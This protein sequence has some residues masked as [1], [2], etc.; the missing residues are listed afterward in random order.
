M[1][2]RTSSGRRPVLFILVL[3][4]F[5]AL[6]VIAAVHSRRND[7]KKDVAGAPAAGPAAAAARET[8]PAPSAGP[9]AQPAAGPSAPGMTTAPV[10]PTPAATISIAPDLACGEAGCDDG[11]PCTVD[12]CDHA[13]GECVHPP[14]ICDDFNP[15]TTE[16]CDPETGCRSDPIPDGA[17]CGPAVT[18]QAPAVC[19]AGQCVSGRLNCDDGDPCTSDGCDDQTGECVH[20]TAGV[21]NDFNGCTLDSCD[22]QTGQC[23]H[24]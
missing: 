24:T 18:C 10:A 4:A 13:T 21:C 5:L 1:H 12:R 6:P 17:S 20:S 9:G 16:T 11:D 22:A 14:V 15:C 19:Q 3:A 8:A 23:H 7:P 2:L